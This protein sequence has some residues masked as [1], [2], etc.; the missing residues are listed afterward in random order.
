MMSTINTHKLSVKPIAREHKKCPESTNTNDLQKE[1][2]KKCICSNR[3][4]F[5]ILHAQNVHR[6]SKNMMSK[7]KI[8]ICMV[9]RFRFKAHQVDFD[10]VCTRGFAD[11]S[12]S[13]SCIVGD[14][15][16]NMK[17]DGKHTQKSRMEISRV[18][19]CVCGVRKRKQR[20]HLIISSESSN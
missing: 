19:V 17:L 4:R 18:C 7:Y 13:F 20:Y 9:V 6:I 11:P 5:S 8:L 16:H 2:R 14:H 15:G 12:W 10:A 3:A 1:E